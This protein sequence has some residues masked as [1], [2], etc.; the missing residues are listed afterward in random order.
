[1]SEVILLLIIVG[2]LGFIVY[3]DNQHRKERKE[4]YSRLMARDLHDYSFH[5]QV[6]TPSAPAPKNYLKEA[7]DAQA[8]ERAMQYVEE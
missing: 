1:M 8:R 7:Y 6:T 5:N 3:S 4:L 2:L